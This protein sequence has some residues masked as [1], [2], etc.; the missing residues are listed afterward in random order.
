MLE[1]QQLEKQLGEVKLYCNKLEL[2]AASIEEASVLSEINRIQKTQIDGLKNEVQNKDTVIHARE[3]RLATLEYDLSCL[4]NS[5]DIQKHYEGS[6]K[7]GVQ[8]GRE[9]MRTLYC[10]LSKKQ[11]DVQTLTL[12]LAQRNEE[13]EKSVA[14]VAVFTDKATGLETTIATLNRENESVID[15]N[16]TLKDVI[17]NNSAQ[18][19]VLKD[20]SA[21][22][23]GQV[24]DL[25]RRLSESRFELQELRTQNSEGEAAL[26]SE[27]Q[28]LR[29]DN[30]T[31]AGSVEHLEG[32]VA[33]KDTLHMVTEKKL[34]TEWQ[35]LN[36]HK[37]LYAETL[38]KNEILESQLA[39]F[40]STYTET[41]TSKE[42]ATRQLD[43]KLSHSKARELELTVRYDEL[44]SVSEKSEQMIANVE[45]QLSGMIMQRDEAVE[46]LQ[47][48]MLQYKAI[49]RQY[50]NERSMRSNAEEKCR[51]AEKEALDLKASKEYALNAVLDALQQEKDKVSKLERLLGDSSTASYYYEKSGAKHTDADVPAVAQGRPEVEPSRGA[52]VG[53]RS[54][55]PASAPLSVLLASPPAPSASASA[56][57]AKYLPVPSESTPMSTPGIKAMSFADESLSHNGSPDVISSPTV[58]STME[59]NQNHSFANR[60]NS[61]LTDHGS[62]QRV[63]ENIARLKQQFDSMVTADGDG[64]IVAADS[65]SAHGNSGESTTVLHKHDSNRGRNSHG[66][67]VDETCI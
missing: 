63:S 3:Q 36:E 31:L 39:L 7:G 21:K 47:Q 67:S 27:N 48:C 62:M 9:M 4:R 1:K 34:Q 6:V 55:S 28:K 13:L 32:L 22:Y 58:D 8:S 19:S 24:E 45:H 50:L 60:S 41:L 42:E 18:I 11:T 51:I 44:R 20:I 56:R 25:A 5:I 59:D 54:L 65:D 15:E 35:K 29:E 38:Q 14:N 16:S 30:T 52:G 40:K 46:A 64:G 10:D 33:Q 26:E 17:A 57:A 66:G 49:N 23:Q 37:T 43:S 2:H 61:N 12:R 53:A